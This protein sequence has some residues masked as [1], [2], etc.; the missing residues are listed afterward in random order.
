[1]K[2]DLH[3]TE[4]RF[5]AMYDTDNPHGPDTDFYIELAAQLETK[6]ILDL[7][8][9]TGL[10]TRA[11]A[12][13]GYNITG[14]D[15]STEMIAYGKQQTH[16]DL[17]QWVEGTASLLGTPDADLA[18]MTGNVAQVFLDDEVWLD[19]LKSIHA[20]LCKGGHVAFESRNP[21]ARAWE[22]WTPEA[23]REVIDSPYGPL[24]CWLEVIQVSDAKVHF[25]GHN[26]FQNTGETLVID[27]TLKF[28]TKQEITKVLE[29]VGFEIKNIYGGWQQQT[30]TDTSPVMVFVAQKN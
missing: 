14:I 2:L 6:T 11:L 29:M 24:E 15:P 25:Q 30:M 17:V 10:L 19:T 18:L 3:Y 9:G 27:S 1:M 26:I 12:A 5:V 13:K 16:G 8:C 7:G 21:L 28:R 22:S 20:A 4:P 23:T